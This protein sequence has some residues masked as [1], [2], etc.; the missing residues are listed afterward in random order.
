MSLGDLQYSACPRMVPL[1][2]IPEA[3]RRPGARTCVRGWSP[4]CARLSAAGEE[5]GGGGAGRRCSRHR[6]RGSG[7]LAD[8]GR[9]GLTCA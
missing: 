1:A 4:A 2:Q 7:G 6:A 9:D 8:Q 3:A 5:G